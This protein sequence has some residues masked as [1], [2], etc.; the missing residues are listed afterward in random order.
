MCL[1]LYVREMRFT[2]GKD[3]S[4]VGEQ[5][6]EVHHIPRAAVIHMLKQGMWKKLQIFLNLRPEFGPLGTQRSFFQT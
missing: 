5:D 3:G 1:Y 6:A 4:W 2:K